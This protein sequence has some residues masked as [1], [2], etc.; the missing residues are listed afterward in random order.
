MSIIGLMLKD[1]V[2][3]SEEINRTIF[4]DLVYESWYSSYIQY[5]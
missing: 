3:V 5:G 4:F 1:H 2:T